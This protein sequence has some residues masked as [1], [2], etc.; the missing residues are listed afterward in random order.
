MENKTLAL[1]IERRDGTT[2]AMLNNRETSIEYDIDSVFE[3]LCVDKIRDR[4]VM[5][6]KSDDMS[7]SDTTLYKKDIK[8]SVGETTKYFTHEAWSFSLQG[9]A[10]ASESLAYLQKRR[11]VFEEI[12]AWAQEVRKENFVLTEK[13]C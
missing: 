4:T 2:T 9:D 11:K 8:V 3:Y 5:E 13:L 10:N 1:S 6:W 7:F 12:R